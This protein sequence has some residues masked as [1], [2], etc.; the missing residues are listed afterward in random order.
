[1]AD[2]SVSDGGTIRLVLNSRDNVQL[3]RFYAFMGCPDRPLSRSGTTC[4]VATVTSREVATDLAKWGIVP[5]K[6]YVNPNIPETL[7]K[8]AAFWLGL[9]DGDGTITARRGRAGDVPVLVFVGSHRVMNKASAF[10]RPFAVRNNVTYTPR[11]V[12]NIWI[13]QLVGRPAVNALAV[14]VDS[15]PDSLARKRLLADSAV[16]WRRAERCDLHELRQL[17][18]G[19]NGQLLPRN[20]AK[21]EA[22]NDDPAA[23]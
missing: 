8:N 11:R 19:P 6:T 1:M 2:G 23:S 13:V 12:N 18:R 5:R 17:P 15:F 9:L 7:A 22:G 10:L 3:R 20:G 14:M 21:D 4:S 16:K